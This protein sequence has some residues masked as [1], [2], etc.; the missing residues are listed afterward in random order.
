MIKSQKIKEELNNYLKVTIYFNQKIF[1]YFS[2]YKIFINPPLKQISNFKLKNLFNE[3]LALKNKLLKYE[4]LHPNY[5][6]KIEL[7]DLENCYLMFLLIIYEN[8]IKEIIFN[9]IEITVLLTFMRTLKYDQFA[10]NFGKLLIIFY[11]KNYKQINIITYSIENHLID[12]FE[13]LKN[14]KTIEYTTFL[15]FII[16]SFFIFDKIFIENILKNL[17][18]LFKNS[19]Y[20]LKELLII[21]INFYNENNLNFKKFLN[22][23]LIIYKLTNVSGK[24]IIVH[25]IMQSFNF[26]INKKLERNHLLFNLLIKVIKIAFNQNLEIIIR[27]FVEELISISDFINSNSILSQLF[28]EELFN[29]VYSSCRNKSKLEKIS[30]LKVLRIMIKADVKSFR[31]SLCNYNINK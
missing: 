2:N 25:A 3:F 31:K 18:I 7:K 9:E 11:E 19:I 1:K 23:I 8:K 28:I 30:C 21:L 16:Y 26:K 5:F 20:E 27:Y 14:N 15:I 4:N 22:K 29:E 24:L 17:K 6:Q 13:C 12:I 10:L